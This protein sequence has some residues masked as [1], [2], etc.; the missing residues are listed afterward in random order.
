MPLIYFEVYCANCG[1]GLCKLTTVDERSGIKLVIKPCPECL[2]DAEIDGFDKGF[3][4]GCEVT[5]EQAEE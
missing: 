5:R 1:E 4:K 2:K 3:F